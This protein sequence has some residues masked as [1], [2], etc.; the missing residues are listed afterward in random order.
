MNYS[1]DIL[2]VT[3]YPLTTHYDDRGDLT[4]I[5]RNEWTKNKLPVQ[6]NFVRSKPH[7]LRG[8]HLHYVHTDYLMLLDGTMILTLKDLRPNSPTL[9]VSDSIEVK[10]DVPVMICIPPGVGHGF[11]FPVLS[12]HVYAVTDYW[13]VED[14]LACRW[15]DPELNISW[16]IADESSLLISKKDK[17][18]PSFKEMLE[19]FYRHWK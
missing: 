17:E 3:F 16:S 10:S 13:N 11:Y 5:F 1:S 18:A 6:W 9:D 12:S 2:D 8:F 14:E 4:E 15:D 7:V 19:I